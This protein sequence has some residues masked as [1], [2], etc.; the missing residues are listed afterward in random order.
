MPDQQ[1]LSLTEV[2]IASFLVSGTV[3]GL[4]KM[5]WKMQHGFQEYQKQG[6]VLMA[7]DNKRER[8]ML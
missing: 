8:E 1:G 5:Q 4:L 7:L 6:S 3:L 2:L